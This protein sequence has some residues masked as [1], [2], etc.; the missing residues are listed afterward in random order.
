MAN[1]GLSKPWIAEYLPATKTYKDAFQCGKA[2]ST[3]ITPN[4]NEA[5]LY[6]D[7]VQVEY[8]TEFTNATLSLGVDRLPVQAAELL[9]GHS[10]TEQGV[11][12]SAG[13]DAGK[14]VGYGFV[15]AEMVD[16]VKRYRGCVLHKCKFA[17]GEESF[18]TKGDSITFST[19]TLSGTAMADEDNNWRTKSQ[20]YDTES[21]ADAWVQQFLGKT[22]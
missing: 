5:S 3:S 9:F 1:F 6:A 18:T 19:P 8:V 12:T 13:N 17:E 2:V 11:E 10:T 22:E 4:S 7:N 21:A 15:T 14:Y 16:G 20:Y